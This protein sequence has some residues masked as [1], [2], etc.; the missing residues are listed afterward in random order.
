MG[1][2]ETVTTRENGAKMCR[3]I[4]KEKKTFKYFSEDVKQKGER[5]REREK[6]R[7]RERERE[8]EKERERERER[9]RERGRE[10]DQEKT[11]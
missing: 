5:K 4:D 6:E 1:D 8:R 7:K 3:L 2:R 10:S 9:D 11:R